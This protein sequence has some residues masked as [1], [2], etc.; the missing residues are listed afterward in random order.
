MFLVTETTLLQVYLLLQLAC[1]WPLVFT[2][3]RL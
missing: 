2:Q 1:C 3:S